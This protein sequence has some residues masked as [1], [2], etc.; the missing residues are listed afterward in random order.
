MWLGLLGFQAPTNDDQNVNLYS[1]TLVKCY[2]YLWSFDCSYWVQ[3]WFIT[4][5][6]FKEYKCTQLAYSDDVLFR[7][8]CLINKLKKEREAITQVKSA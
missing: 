6:L 5:L 1:F 2:T 8:T 7:I 4:Y 3:F